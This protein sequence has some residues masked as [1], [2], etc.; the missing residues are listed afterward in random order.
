MSM[1]GEIR[2][3]ARHVYADGQAHENAE[4]RDELARRGFNKGGWS[5]QSNKSRYLTG[6]ADATPSCCERGRRQPCCGRWP[7]SSGART[8]KA[9]TAAKPGA[10]ENPGKT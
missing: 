8:C 2:R 10:G 9:D 7:T 4:V 6:C 3:A 5:V 1:A